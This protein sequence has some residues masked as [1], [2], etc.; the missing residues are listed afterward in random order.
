[1]PEIPCY[2]Y[3]NPSGDVGRFRVE[4]VSPTDPNLDIIAY[5]FQ[6]VMFDAWAQQY[7]DI[8]TEDQI[9]E[10]VDPDDHSKVEAQHDRL[11][12]AG[13]GPR[14][15]LYV[16]TLTQDHAEVTYEPSD[17]YVL[18]IGKTEVVP[19]KLLRPALAD[20]SN[21]FVSPQY[22]GQGIGYATL[23][24]MLDH[25]SLDKQLVVYELLINRGALQLLGRLTFK[26]IQLWDESYFGEDRAQGR[27]QGPTVG[28]LAEIIESRQPWIAERQQLTPESEI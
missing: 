17:G 10:M 23:R 4:L 13:S 8:F 21:L 12:A 11:L 19:K 3:R 6:D 25:F 5:N 24:S 15:P 16:Q 1:M 22:Q 18:A 2:A 26:Q 7:K 28:D 9:K 14:R 20:V 27:F